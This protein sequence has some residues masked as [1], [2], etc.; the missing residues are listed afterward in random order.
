MTR[1]FSAQGADWTRTRKIHNVSVNILS[2]S[3][4]RIISLLF[5]IFFYMAEPFLRLF[6]GN[7][8]EQDQVNRGVSRGLQNFLKGGDEEVFVCH[9]SGVIVCIVDVSH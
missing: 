2:I 3:P 8:V 4:L 6:L 7:G 9:V 1:L 5:K